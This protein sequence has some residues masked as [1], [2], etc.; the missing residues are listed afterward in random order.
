MKQTIGLWKLAGF[1]V[2]SL[3]GTLLHFLYEWFGEPLWIA[4]FSGVN[5]STWEHMKLLFWPMLIFA[6]FERVSFRHVEDFWCIKLRGILLGLGL[7]PILFYTYNGA[8]GKSPDWVNIS[9]FFIAAAAT[10]IY[11]ASKLNK[12]K[13]SC[14]YPKAA[15]SILLI[16]GILFVI[17][18]FTAPNTGIFVDP[19]TGKVG[20]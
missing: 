18:T 9:I 8:V 10:Y 15:L 14:K 2:T 12:E 7:I 6:F 5:E 1:A 3:S 16:I 13:L 11:E 20:I 4:P 19:T 17:F